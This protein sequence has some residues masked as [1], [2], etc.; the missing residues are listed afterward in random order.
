MIGVQCT[1]G[2]F[3]IFKK[4]NNETDQTSSQM[5]SLSLTSLN[6]VV[7]KGKKKQS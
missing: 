2:V 7:K 6:I 1:L 3:F 4:N 5:L